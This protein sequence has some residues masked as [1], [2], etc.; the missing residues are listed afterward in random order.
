[1]AQIGSYATVTV[2]CPG[3]T[4]ARPF[5]KLNLQIEPDQ[6]LLEASSVSPMQRITFI[7]LLYQLE[8]TGSFIASC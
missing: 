2:S 6:I 4:P 3:D 7:L 1:M 8:D 5:F